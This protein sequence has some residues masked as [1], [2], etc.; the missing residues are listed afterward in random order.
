MHE[1]ALKKPHSMTTGFEQPQKLLICHNGV[2][3]L[4]T[5]EQTFC[6]LHTCLHLF[7]LISHAIKPDRCNFLLVYS[8][9]LEYFDF[10]LLFLANIYV[11]LSPSDMHDFSLRELHTFY[12]NLS[13]VKI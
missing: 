6:E 12:H 5:E 3:F 13:F 4:L 2:F 1:F 7:H 8:V 9:I 11:R 10:E